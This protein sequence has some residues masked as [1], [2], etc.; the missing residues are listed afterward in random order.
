MVMVVKVKVNEGELVCPACKR[1]Y[2]I[3]DGILNMILMEDEIQE[4]DKIMKQKQK[5]IVKED[6][7]ED[8]E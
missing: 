3:K 1:S 2:P 7:M 4:R 8:K 5:G 6:K